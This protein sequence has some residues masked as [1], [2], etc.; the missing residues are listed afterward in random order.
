MITAA[1]VAAIV[2]AVGLFAFGRV[3]WPAFPSSNVTQA[4]TTVGQV[5]TIAVLALCVIAYR[6]RRWMRAATVLSW[7][8]LSGFVTVTLGMPLSAT[9]LYLHGVSVDQEFRTEYLTRLTDSAALHDMTYAD[10]PPYYPAGWFWIGGR[11][12]NLLG[13]DGWEMFKPYAIASIAVAAVI[14]LVLWTKLIRADWAIVVGLV[15]AA[16]VVAYGSAEPY[17]AVIAVLIPPVLLLAWGGLHRPGESGRGGW[18][19]VAGTGVFLGIAAAFY[20][21][22]LGFTA[23]A[24]TLMALVAAGLAVRENGSWRGAITPLVR[25]V[26]VAVISGIIA[27]VVWLPYLLDAVR[28]S[29]ADSGTATHYLPDAGAHLPLPMFQFSLAGALCLLGTI[30]LVW[31]ATTSRRA[32]VLGIG[33]I[34]V[35]LWSLLSMAFTVLGGTLLSFRLEP[36]LILLLGTAGVFGFFEFS[37]RLVLATSE[38]P[39]VK[40]SLVVLGLAGL[41]GF[42]QNIPQVLASDITVAYTDTDG[43]GVRADQ[44]PP[45]AAAYFADVDRIITE[46]RPGERHDTVV[47]TSDT[48]FLSFYPYYGFQALTSHYANPLAQF[49]ERTETIESWSDLEAPDQ[50]V[51]ALDELPWRAPDVFVFRKSADGYVLRLAEDV[52]PNDPNVRRY[53]VTLPA[54]LFD[55]PR[56]TIDEVGPFVVVTRVG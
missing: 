48:G 52:Y 42:S 45:G 1:V 8:G 26:A 36:V 46:H 34:A 53:T 55:D 24:V 28:D 49:R 39:R 30:W 43:D 3:S 47:L 18:G 14:A 31:R 5:V 22:Y 15:T 51:T 23:F 2:S 11:L 17:G 9:K 10:L 13:L 4:V 37:R 32:Q 25:L 41:V 7:A 27:L 6:A 33:V 40:A 54:Q 50:L 19:A 44:R 20:T 21:L 16:L 38:N 35:Y 56:F 29:A 12:A